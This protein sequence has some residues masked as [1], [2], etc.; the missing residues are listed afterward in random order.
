M[1]INGEKIEFAQGIDRGVDVLGQYWSVFYTWWYKEEMFSFG[2]CRLY[3]QFMPES[4]HKVC[5]AENTLENIKNM[6]T[7]VT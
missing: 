5:V 7:E 2:S 1:I 3:E 4:I 6:L